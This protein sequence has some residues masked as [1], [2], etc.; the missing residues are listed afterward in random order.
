MFFCLDSKT[1]LHDY[2]AGVITAMP[3]RPKISYGIVDKRITL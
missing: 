3:R 2:G 1:G